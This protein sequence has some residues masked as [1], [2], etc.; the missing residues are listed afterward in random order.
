MNYSVEPIR[1]ISLKGLHWV[2]ASAGTGKTYTLSA[3]IVRALIESYY[4]KQIIATTFTRAASAELKDRVRNRLIE[5]LRFFESRTEFVL[6]QNK[7]HAEELKQKDQ[8]FATLLDKFADQTLY[9]CERIKL[10]LEQMDELFVGTLDSF[11]QKI[12]RE[13]AFESGEVERTEITDD[14]Q[15]HLLQIIQTAIRA[16]VSTQP[17]DLVNLMV[18]ARKIDKA[19]NYLNIVEET[20]TFGSAHLEQSTGE[21]ADF[22]FKLDAPLDIDAIESALS[23]YL[24]ESLYTILNKRSY[25]TPQVF[26]SL[27]KDAIPFFLN[28]VANNDVD[29]LLLDRNGSIKQLTKFVDQVLNAKVFTSKAHALKD[30][31]YADSIFITLKA[32]LDQYVSIVDS[33]EVKQ[34][35]L[36]LFI[37]NRTKEQLPQR[38]K[39]KQETTFTNQSMSLANALNGDNGEI[40]AKS[41][42]SRYPIIIVDEFQDTDYSQDSILKHVWRNEDTCNRTCMIMVGDRKQAIYGFR[43][44]DMLT[45]IQAFNDVRSKHGQFYYLVQNHRTV[46][47]LIDS[48]N[49]LFNQEPDFGEQVSYTVVQAGAK[50]HEKLVDH[51]VVNHNPLRVFATEKDQHSNQIASKIVELLNLA[52]QGHISFNHQGE[53]TPLSENDIAVI[54]RSHRDLDEIQFELEKRGVSVNRHSQRSVF[55]SNVAKDVLVLLSAILEPQD[56]YIKRFLLSRLVNMQLSDLNKIQNDH[57]EMAKI[58]GQFH[59]IREI[60]V[61]QNFLTAWQFCCDA[62]HILDNVSVFKGKESERDILN[63]RHIIELLS[64]HSNNMGYQTLLAWYKQQINSPMLRE[65]ELE[66]PLSTDV[67]VKLMTI[68]KSKGLEFKV[69]FLAKADKDFS[70]LSNLSHYT[71][72]KN[73]NGVERVQR[74]IALKGNESEKV[75]QEHKAHLQAEHLR[76]LYVAITRASHRLY[77]CLAGEL[78]VKTGVGY[79][80][81]KSYS[82]SEGFAL[83]NTQIENPSDALNFYSPSKQAKAN[84]ELHIEQPKKTYFLS[85][86]SSSFSALTSNHA[87]MVLDELVEQQAFD[88]QDENNQVSYDD[89]ANQSTSAPIQ[90]IS[91]TFPKGA[92]AGTY[93]H[94]VLSEIDFQDKDSWGK[95]IYRRLVN[96]YLPLL[97]KVNAL[98]L[99]IKDDA[100]RKDA[101]TAD[102][103]EWFSNFIHNATMIGGVRLA[104]LKQGLYLPEME[105]CFSLADNTFHSDQLISIM[106]KYGIHVPPIN[107]AKTARFFV[108]SMDL[109]YQNNKQFFVADYKSNFLGSLLTDYTDE[110]IVEKGMVQ[111]SYYL[112]AVIYSVALHRYLSK[113]LSSYDIQTHLGGVSYM[114][115]RGVSADTGVFNWLPDHKMIL[116]IDSLL[117]DQQQFNLAS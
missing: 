104:D 55:T 66:R 82:E 37:C 77:L 36:V 40:L 18:A 23:V 17:Q 34:K 48:M 28:S 15:A 63:L 6:D 99:D 58:K 32:L 105:F 84:T 50:E 74:A 88:V 13:F 116:E 10:V 75:E 52:E 26:E 12:L 107:S 43:G 115:L 100:Q 81:S 89:S 69:V 16:W 101:I 90:G 27:I 68:H 2:E 11:T 79:W 5:T 112:Q 60:W 62:F 1:D 51:G 70:D 103:V 87:S 3:I 24:D 110:N 98:Y 94:E 7:A 30:Q 46:P 49:S 108:G 106:A 61:S 29:T 92:I 113:R 67:G 42:R 57:A 19:E 102:M 78:S 44:G 33:L 31:M 64:H 4:P 22:S 80:L 56:T 109:V 59:K 8:L 35:E 9:V 21:F 38:L 71:I 41:I 39:E 83:N 117:S 25:K 85:R 97:N 114:F 65:W 86:T 73:E 20:I 53:N 76:Q 95:V 93:L 14:K 111:S 72:T 47:E 91:M 96:D 45:F 54:A